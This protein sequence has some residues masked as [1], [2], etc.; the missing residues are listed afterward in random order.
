MIIT[1][2]IKHNFLTSPAQ[3][4]CRAKSVLQFNLFFRKFT[5]REFQ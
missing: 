2:N 5:K 3:Q 1:A 4:V